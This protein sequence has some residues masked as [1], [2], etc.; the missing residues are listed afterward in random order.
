MS[1]GWGGRLA[2][3]TQI[4]RYVDLAKFLDLLTRRNLYFA[5]LDKLEDPF[6]GAIPRQFLID[7]LPLPEHITGPEREARQSKNVRL[8]R[9]MLRKSVYVNCWVSG[10]HESEAMWRL[11]SREGIA[12]RSTV[13]RLERSIGV[14]EQS[15]TGVYAVQYHGTNDDTFISNLSDNVSMA[16]L[17]KRK[18]FEHEQ[19]IRAIWFNFPPKRTVEDTS[20]WDI[21]SP[22]QPKGLYAPVDVRL[23]IERIYI[24]PGRPDWFR[25]LV[26]DLMKRIDLSNVSVVKSSL[27]DS[28]DLFQ[29][30]LIS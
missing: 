15:P 18:S 3:D 8:L 11:Y 6:E 22:E 12:I 27:D 21:D 26:T 24:S 1:D 16:A 30:C 7:R 9:E 4:W 5:R 13:G 2:S 19:E 25:E 14:T 17:S 28:V 23:L 29:L 10:E 20:Y